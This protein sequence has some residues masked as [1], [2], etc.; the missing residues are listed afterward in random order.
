MSE[1]QTWALFHIQE[2]MPTEIINDSFEEA[3]LNDSSNSETIVRDNDCWGLRDCAYKIDK[4]T[5]YN[6]WDWA[7]TDQ[8][9]PHNQFETNRYLVPVQLFSILFIIFWI[10]YFVLRFTKHE[11]PLKN[12]IIDTLASIWILTILWFLFIV[13]I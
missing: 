4:T 8:C 2:E 12:A 13:F 6:C 11:H 5:K 10:C 3:R 7:F 1:Q 9:I